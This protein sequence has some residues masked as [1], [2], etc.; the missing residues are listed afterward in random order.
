MHGR[1]ISNIA[2]DILEL[3]QQA[4]GFNSADLL[5]YP[6]FIQKYYI[7]K[8]RKPYFEKTEPINL[9]WFQIKFF[10]LLKAQT[11]HCLYH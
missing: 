2:T 4:L 10:K 6:R 11:Q 9:K 5:N 7:Y 1:I 3:K 8:K